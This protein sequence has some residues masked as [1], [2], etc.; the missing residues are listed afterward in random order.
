MPDVL[1]LSVLGAAALT[2]GIKFLYGQA[3]E[4]LRRR[5]D[6]PDDANPGDAEQVPGV[7]LE[8]GSLPQPDLDEVE[9]LQAELRVLRADLHEYASGVDAVDPADRTLLLRVDA[10]RQVLE[11][12]YGT[13][14]VFEGE[15]AAAGEVRGRVAAGDVAGYVAA[16]R[17][18]RLPGGLISGEVDVDRV[19]HGG[20]VVG[21]DIGRSR[22]DGS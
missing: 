11:V 12:I 21:V 19:Q 1:S 10:L 5:R 18:D 9:R 7:L 16:V 13:A 3:G 6:R 14:L 17:A 20:E 22:P 8:P 15:Q 2:E 4:L